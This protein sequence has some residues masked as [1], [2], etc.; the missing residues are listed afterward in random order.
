MPMPQSMFATVP[1][2]LIRRPGDDPVDWATEL[3]YKTF[4]FPGGNLAYTQIFGKSDWTVEYLIRLESQTD[5][6]RL[7]ALIGT[8]QTLRVPFDTT[9]YAGT[10]SFQFLGELY[11]EFDR[12]FLPRV[13]DIRGR[14]NGSVLATLGLSREV[15][16]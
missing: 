15:P 7:H 13:T 9:A 16:A 1:I 10:R 3:R 11:K 14:N 5:F 4:P 12:I 8:R 2:T 6:Q